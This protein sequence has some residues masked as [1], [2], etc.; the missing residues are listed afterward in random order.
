MVVILLRGEIL[1]VIELADY[2]TN[3]KPM[4]SHLYIVAIYIT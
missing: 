4:Y 2:F 1:Y 3:G